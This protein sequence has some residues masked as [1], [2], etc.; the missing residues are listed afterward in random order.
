VIFPFLWLNNVLDM[1]TI[2]APLTSR[3]FYDNGT[4]FSINSFLTSDYSV[5]ETKYEAG[6]SA[7]MAPMYALG[8]MYSFIALTGC[9]SHIICFH[10]PGKYFRLFGSMM[11]L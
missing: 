8:F 6:P 11:P 3:L 9:I 4:R 7:N 2:G 10:G 5:N 1:K